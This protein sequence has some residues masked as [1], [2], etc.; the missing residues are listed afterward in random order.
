M[1]TP[2]GQIPVMAKRS[3][4]GLHFWKRCALAWPVPEPI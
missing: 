1:R 3:G 2:F 4:P